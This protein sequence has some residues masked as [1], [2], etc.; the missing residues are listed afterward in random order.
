[1]IIQGSNEPLA[2]QFNEAVTVPGLVVTLW[3]GDEL[4]KTWQKSDMVIDG[5]TVLCPLT[6]VETAAMPSVGHL[7]RIKGLDG[8]GQT[9]FWEDWAIDVL[10]RGDKGIQPEV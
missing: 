8:N 4:V 6:A 1:M 5:D 10:Y 2:I 3:R 7:V 9:V